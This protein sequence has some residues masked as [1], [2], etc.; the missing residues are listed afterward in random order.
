MEDAIYSSIQEKELNWENF[1]EIIDLEIENF[2]SVYERHFN[3]FCFNIM[4]KK[5]YH[6]IL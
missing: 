4:T 2:L 5:Y 3:I 6:L 1:P